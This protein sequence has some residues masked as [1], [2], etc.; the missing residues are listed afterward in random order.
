MEGREGEVAQVAVAATV[1]MVAMGTV[2]GLVTVRQLEVREAVMEVMAAMAVW[3]AMA[4]RVAKLLSSITACLS[5][6]ITWPLLLAERVAGVESQA[7]LA[8][9]GEAGETEILALYNL[10]ET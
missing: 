7:Y 5:Q 3:V 6:A 2:K 10:M 4:V 8:C 1:A 9:Q